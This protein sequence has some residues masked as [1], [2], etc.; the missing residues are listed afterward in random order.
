[1]R[2]AARLF[3]ILAAAWALGAAGLA[4]P[5]SAIPAAY[6]GMSLSW[7]GRYEVPP[8]RFPA[9][10]LLHASTD[11]FVAGID[12]A[13]TSPSGA[14]GSSTW[15][16]SYS[17]AIL[18]QG[19]SETTKT[20][21]RFRA[22]PAGT[23]FATTVGVTHLVWDTSAAQPACGIMSLQD[24]TEASPALIHY[25]GINHANGGAPQFFASHENDYSNTSAA[26]DGIADIA[27]T[28]VFGTSPAP[29][30]AAKMYYVQYRYTSSTRIGRAYF[31]TN[32]VDWLATTAYGALGVGKAPI[33]IGVFVRSGG[34][35]S[36]GRCRFHFFET[37]TDAAG[38][39]GE[40]GAYPYGAAR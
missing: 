5:S 6:A 39:A 29:A 34:T 30:D 10:G 20:R 4:P 18:D 3:A 16:W 2:R 33:S 21:G 37:R 35:A 1:M 40:I 28:A 11:K 31:S 26:S 8:F 19:A 7:K 14:T 38:A 25:M 9:P 17:G 22:A 27:A 23:D 24:G 32:G 13:W 36:Q 15:T 12:S